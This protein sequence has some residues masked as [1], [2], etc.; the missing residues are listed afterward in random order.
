MYNIHV[1]DETDERPRLVTQATGPISVLSYIANYA[2][3]ALQA[4][5]PESTIKVRVVEHDHDTEASRTL[6][7]FTG[8]A[9]TAALVLK[10]K[11]AKERALTGAPAET[12]TDEDAPATTTRRRGRTA[13]AEPVA[14]E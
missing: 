12:P 3:K 1:E 14:A 10:A 2:V 5:P 11:V 6:V 4:M 9:D 8:D 7:Q 13:P